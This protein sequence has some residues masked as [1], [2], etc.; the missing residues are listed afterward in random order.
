MVLGVRAAPPKGLAILT[1]DPD[2]PSP[3]AAM[4]VAAFKA[5][6]VDFDLQAGADRIPSGPPAFQSRE[7]TTALLITARGVP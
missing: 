2:H 7:V 4:L 5:A 1:P 6:K 3:E